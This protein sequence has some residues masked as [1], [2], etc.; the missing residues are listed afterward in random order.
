VDT[1][2]LSG[3]LVGGLMER[4]PQRHPHR[5]RRIRL[6][7]LW[8]SATLVAIVALAPAQSEY[9]ADAGRRLW[10]ARWAWPVVGAAVI[11]VLT[12]PRARRQWPKR[13]RIE[14]GLIA[15]AALV[16]LISAVGPGRALL[17]L[18]LLAF[19]GLVAAWALVLPRRLAP[20]L[21]AEVLDS[22]EGRDR[23]ELADARIKLQNDLRTTALQAIAGMALLVGAVLA[24]QQLTEQGQQTAA[25]RELTRQGQ[26]S[27][28]F[29][30]AI[31]QLGSDRLEVRL[32]GIY[33][34]EQIARQAP[35]NQAAVTQVLVAYLHRRVP[36]SAKPTA[37]PAEELRVRAPDV[38]AALTVLGRR[39]TGT[40]VEDQLDLR[41]LDL[42]GADLVNANLSGVDL[43][44]ADLRR[45]NLEATDLSGATLE[46]ADLSG[47]LLD[48][49]DLS[50]AVLAGM[51]LSR[52]N[53]TARTHF[54]GAYVDQYTSWPAGFDP[55]RAGVQEVPEPST[56]SYV[57]SFERVWS[58]ARPLEAAPTERVS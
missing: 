39:Q 38:Q 24:F 34:L 35:D 48:E 28:R 45:A 2:L 12:S 56:H 33:G 52:A 5:M 41:Q 20:P 29:T 57:E 55:H 3:D 50:G 44:G 10:Q 16:G 9:V 27:E 58:S 21:P 51:N 30:R 14:L 8:V 18:G 49:A 43:R 53:F 1:L 17:V 42:A 31:D 15:F 23:L 37:P 4:P 54:T 22:L 32:G 11:T 6:G 13:R 7:V 40:G 36:R 25:D 47:A 46:G 26:A 19:V